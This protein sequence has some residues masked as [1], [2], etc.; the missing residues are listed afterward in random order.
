M[1]QRNFWGSIWLVDFTS[2][3]LTDNSVY[4]ELSI[5]K[6]YFS[7]VHMYHF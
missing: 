1:G 3:G 6:S 4:V 7:S 5:Y 2:H